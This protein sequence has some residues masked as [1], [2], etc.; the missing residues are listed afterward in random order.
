MIF[1]NQLST[2]NV[3]KLNTECEQKLK[4]VDQQL[5]SIKFSLI[6]YL[7]IYLYSVTKERTSTF[8]SSSFEKTQPFGK[9]YFAAI[10]L[11]RVRH[12]LFSSCTQLPQMHS[13]LPVLHYANHCIVAFQLLF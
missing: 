5:Q 11:R 7:I 8:Q 3:G 10:I 12:N 4:N 13:T 1:D 2:R 9:V 6:T